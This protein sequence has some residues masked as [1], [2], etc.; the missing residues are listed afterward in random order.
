MVD[1]MDKGVTNRAFKL[2]RPAVSR[3]SECFQAR[4]SLTISFPMLRKRHTDI[5]I[6]NWRVEMEA[7][8]SLSLFRHVKLVYEHVPFL[9]KVLNKKYRN[10][11][12]K[13]R[14]SSH[15]LLIETGRYTGVPRVERRCM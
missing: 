2:K 3:K 10:T 8:S 9:T 4:W 6:T 1:D 15:P 12:S 13:L 7:C 5:Y 14:L 11:I